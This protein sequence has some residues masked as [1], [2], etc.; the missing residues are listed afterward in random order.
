VP[1]RSHRSPYRQHE[2]VSD[3]FGSPLQQQMAEEWVRLHRDPASG[4]LLRRWAQRH[5]ALGGL[6]RPGDVLD[7]IDGA[8]PAGKDELLRALLLQFQAGQQLAGRI[9]LQAMLPKLS[10]YAFRT[11]V[12][13]RL[14]RR[15][16]DRLQLVVCEF[17][18][19]LGAFP[20]ARRTSRLAANLALETLHRVTRLSRLPELATAPETLAGM[21]EGAERLHRSADADPMA[22]LAAGPDAEWDL[23]ALL[24]WAVQRGVLTHADADLL[25][26]LYGASDVSRAYRSRALHSGVSGAALRQRAHRA[27]VR[28]ASA[29][30]RCRD[31]GA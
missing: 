28:L 18:E 13:A 8:E 24:A 19:V 6:D 30:T 29:V 4:L 17:W 25:Q 2:Q 12:A 27:R 16:D 31:L 3:P 20:V 22:M 14:E 11:A 26:H 10:H 7:A 21:V 23:T 1:A 9:L 5:P 15:P